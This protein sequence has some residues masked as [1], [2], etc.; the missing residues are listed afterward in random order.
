MCVYMFRTQ[1]QL[2]THYESNGHKNKIRKMN[3]PKYKH[4]C[5]DCN[6]MGLTSTDLKRHLKSK[7]HEKNLKLLEMLKDLN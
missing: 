6:Y 1:K 2:D 7:R 3:D 4:I 5:K